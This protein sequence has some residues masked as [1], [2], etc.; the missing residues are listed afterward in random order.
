MTS[1]DEIEQTKSR[2]AEIEQRL[3]RQRRRVEKLL[4]DR[5]PADEAQA[6]LL[7][8]EQ[9]LLAMARYLASLNGDLDSR[10][11][12]SKKPSRRAN[13]GPGKKG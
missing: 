1:N 9:S 8:L 12:A 3:V 5:H 7:I 4:I 6:Q 10:A 13:A 2:I 11:K